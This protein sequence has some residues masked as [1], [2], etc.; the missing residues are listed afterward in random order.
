GRGAAAARATGQR[1]GDENLLSDRRWYAAELNLAQ[2]AWQ[3]GQIGL[4]RQKLEALRPQPPDGP[5]LRGFE[6]YYLERLCRL[7]LRRLSGHTGAVR[8]VARSPDGRWLASAG[9]DGTIKL[10]DTASGQERRTIRGH[11]RSVRGMAFSP[12][13]GRL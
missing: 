3:R 1:A 10:W 5:D 2:Q 11:K 9:D 6:W 8:G 4:V 12:D 13:G 7:E